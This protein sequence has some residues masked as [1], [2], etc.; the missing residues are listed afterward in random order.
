MLVR[1]EYWQSEEDGRWYFHL[2][3]PNGGV[4][5]HSGSYDTEDDCLKGIED[6]RRHSRTAI[7]V[8]PDVA[9]YY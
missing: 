8:Q 6:V 3:A 4:M 5:V 2:L 9:A 1:F 7:V